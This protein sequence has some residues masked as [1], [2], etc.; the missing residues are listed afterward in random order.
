MKR[1][2]ICLPLMACAASG[3]QGSGAP[4]VP[5]ANADTCNAG[6][7]AY[8]VGADRDVLEKTLILQPVRIVTP[9][10][11]VTM[12]FLATRLNIALDEKETV[13]RLS[14]G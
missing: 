11:A 4:R 12:D 3:P 1:L 2:L 10:Q 8:L 13:V 7:Y 9:G 14:C 5:D 6:K